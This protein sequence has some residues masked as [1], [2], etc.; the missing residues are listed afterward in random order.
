MAIHY[1]AGGDPLNIM[2][3][4]G[5]GHTDMLDSVWYV[6]DVV[7][8]CPDFSLT[9]PNCHQQQQPIAQDFLEKSMANFNCVAGAIDGIVIWI[10]R[11]TVQDCEEVGCSSGKFFCAQ[12]GKFGLNCQAVSDCHGQILDMSIVFPASLSDLLAF[13][14]SVSTRGCKIP[15]SWLLTYVSLVT[16]DNA[17]L[18]SPYMATPYPGS[19]S[20]VKDAYNFYHSQC[21][22]FGMLTEHWGILRST[23]PTNITIHKT[24]ALVYSLA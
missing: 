22:A 10:T 16:I 24:I 20:R 9:Y 18:N 7:N 23:M 2:S 3:S 21:C 1:F 8:S 4:F 14:G 12:K 15:I 6:V 19:V 13:E 11:P 5:V 17:Y